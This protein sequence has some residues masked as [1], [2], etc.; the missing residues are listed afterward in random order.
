MITHDNL[1]R[2]VAAF[3][4]GFVIIGFAA[5]AH[6]TPSPLSA[7]DAAAVIAAWRA[8]PEFPMPA[9]L[10]IQAERLASADPAVRADADAA[11]ARAATRL[12]TLE[13]GRIDNPRAVDADWALRVAYDAQRDFDAARDGGRV[14][15]WVA[16]LPRTNPGYL[17]LLAERRRYEAIRHGGGWPSVPEGSDLR[18]GAA[19]GRVAALRARLETEGFLAAT[20]GAPAV[21]DAPLAAAVAVFQKHHR[22]QSDG[23]VN[24]RTLR[25]LN[26]P[27]EDRL[28]AIDASLERERWLPDRLPPERIEVDV[29]RAHATLFA[30]DK[31]VLTMRAIVGAPRHRTPIFRARVTGIVFNPPWN[32]PTSIAAAELYPKE[33]RFPGYF[34]GHGFYV[35]DGRLI[36]RA[37]PKAS[38]GLVK[39]DLDDPFGVYLHDTPARGLFKQHHRALSHGCMRL[40]APRELAAALLSTQGWDRGAI[41][42]IIAA[43]ATK[44]VGLRAPMPTI[45]VYRTAQIGPDGRAMFRRDIYGWDAKL[46]AALSRI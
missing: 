23:V 35:A 21:F 29:A 43:G 22:T 33:R 4:M 45:V 14:P 41:D 15:A 16:T 24:A 32:V 28:R 40:E 13:H 30:G 10:V 20:A 26:V 19:G 36:Q 44:R 37:G 34:A 9:D 38:L 12:A 39:F 1:A 7:T 27:V 17:A 6:A 31:P 18:L 3:L 25:A 8:A 46:I 2:S 11:L 5:L 42:A